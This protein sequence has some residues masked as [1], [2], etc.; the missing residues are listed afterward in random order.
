[1]DCTAGGL[2][3]PG[4]YAASLFYEKKKVIRYKDKMYILL[5][6]CYKND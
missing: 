3:P 2:I 4:G 1:M 5:T 6:E